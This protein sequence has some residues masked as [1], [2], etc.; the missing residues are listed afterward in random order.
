MF[1]QN[2]IKEFFCSIHPDETIQGVS[3]QPNAENYL[4]CKE[5]PTNPNPGYK[6]SIS[7][8][9]FLDFAANF[10]LSLKNRAKTEDSTLQSLLQLLSVKEESLAKFAKH[11]EE[12]KQ[13]VNEA[14]STIF[15]EFTLL[16]NAKKE[17]NSVSHL[18]N[19]Y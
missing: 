7:F 3:V 2:Q 12:E 1:R 19:S 14:F 5:C 17:E 18:T 13:K 6:D 8:Q 9:K 15:Q 11:I 16:F 10:Y 4:Y